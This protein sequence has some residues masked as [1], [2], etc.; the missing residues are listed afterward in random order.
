MQI[1]L[2]KW[3]TTIKFIIARVHIK[4]SA[5]LLFLKL[6]YYT[7]AN[8]KIKKFWKSDGFIVIYKTSILLLKL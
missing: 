1:V 6:L 2:K 3:V 5:V 8:I 4:T 7:L